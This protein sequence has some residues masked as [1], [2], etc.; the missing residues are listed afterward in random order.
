MHKYSRISSNSVVSKYSTKYSFDLI[1][2][3][4][5]KNDTRHSSETGV[6]KYNMFCFTSMGVNASISM[7]HFV[8][9]FCK[10]LCRTVCSSSAV[11][12][13]RILTDGLL[14]DSNVLKNFTNRLDNIT[15]GWSVL[16]KCSMNYRWVSLSIL[17]MIL[18]DT[19]KLLKSLSQFFENK[20]QRLL[21]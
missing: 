12:L 2:S 8:A 7:L 9:I 19:L 5:F 20:S 15:C 13:A 10:L 16:I 18:I 4:S 11:T 1:K 21:E 14:H 17:L 3:N 6:A